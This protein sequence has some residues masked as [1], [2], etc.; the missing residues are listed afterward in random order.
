M[1]LL[2]PSNLSICSLAAVYDQR[3]CE[4][5]KKNSSVFSL[6]VICEINVALSLQLE[7][8]VLVLALVLSFITT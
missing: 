3:R 2:D 6:S 5:Q 1:N 7:I 8:F 4:K